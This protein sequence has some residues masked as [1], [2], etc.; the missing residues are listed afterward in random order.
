MASELHAADWVPRL[1]L[2]QVRVL[3]SR[4]ASLA[5]NSAAELPDG[6]RLLQRVTGMLLPMVKMRLL[7]QP[8]SVSV[9]AVGK[10]ADSAQSKVGS[11]ENRVSSIGFGDLCDVVAEA[12]VERL[13]AAS[14]WV[15]EGSGYVRL[16][17]LPA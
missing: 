3:F 16:Q 14:G 13:V 15:Q 5:N 4:L 1:T 10:S 17:P 12:G 6:L 11:L 7:Q 9:E 8:L 2:E